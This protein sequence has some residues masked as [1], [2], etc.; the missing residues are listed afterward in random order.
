MAVL[1]RDIRVIRGSTSSA[2][3]FVVVLGVLM[4]RGL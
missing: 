1:S 4:S 3:V 2:G